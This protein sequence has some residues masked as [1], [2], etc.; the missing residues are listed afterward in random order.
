MTLCI[1]VKFKFNRIMVHL[2][3][4]KCK[5]NVSIK[6]NALIFILNDR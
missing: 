3:L 1:K 4:I 2:M 5:A 6:F